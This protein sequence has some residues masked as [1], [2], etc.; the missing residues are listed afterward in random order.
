MIVLVT[1]I[2][3]TVMSSP[4]HAQF[5]LGGQLV[6]RGEYRHGYG[7]LIADNADPAAFI[8]QRLRL[9]GSYKWEKITLFASIQD[10]RTW[11]NTSQI[12]LTDNLLSIHEAWIK[13]PFNEFWSVQLG[14]QELNYD[15]VRFL[16]NLDWVLQARAHDFARIRY[17]KSNFKLHI[18][19]GFNQS[20]ELLSGNLLTTPDQYKA[21]QMIR[22]ENKHGKFDYSLLFWNNGRQYVQR[23][24]LGQV[25]EK[26]TRYIH[27]FGIP[28]ARYQLGKLQ[29]SAF[30]YHQSGKDVSG[31]KLDAYDVSLQAAYTLS[32]DDLKNSRLKFLAGYEVI[33]GNDQSDPDEANH[34]FEPMYGT[35]HVHNGYM[36]YF[37]AGGRHSHSV[38]LH[39]AFAGITYHPH[40]KAFISTQVHSFAADGVIYNGNDQMDFSLG[41]EIDATVGYVFN[42]AI[43]VQ[44]GYSQMFASPSLKFLQQVP[45]ASDIQNWVY[46]MLIFRPDSDKK[47]IGVVL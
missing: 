3:V 12:K 33:S 37:Y 4:I 27:T 42:K 25:V 23:D 31:T 18:G 7:R 29:M 19:A 24:S 16:G 26:D 38:G 2:T 1:L 35:N 36:D 5:S 6:Q 8:S 47:F 46:V 39:D 9:E 41:T 10:I 15:N 22:L 43:S 40:D 13:L 34:S 17:E 45:N 20:G 32:I 28:Q 11:G 44:A 14:R 30:Y 21:A